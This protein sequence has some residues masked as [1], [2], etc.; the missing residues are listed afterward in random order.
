MELINILRP[1]RRFGVAIISTVGRSEAPQALGESNRILPH[2]VTCH[3]NLTFQK[4]KEISRFP[5]DTLPP[6]DYEFLGVFFFY[7][8]L[9]LT[10]E[11]RP[12]DQN[13]S[14]SE[15]KSKNTACIKRNNFFYKSLKDNFTTIFLWKS[16]NNPTV[17]WG[18]WTQFYFHKIIWE[19]MPSAQLLESMESS[20][21]WRRVR[22]SQ[23]FISN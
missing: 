11:L 15:S 18:Y 22:I 21:R 6:W 8:F 4:E 13:I 14:N 7:C 17:N 23:N 19:R 3:S 10:E 5:H 12:H 1:K 20:G 2:A 16:W 9:S